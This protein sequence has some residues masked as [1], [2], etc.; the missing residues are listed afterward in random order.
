VTESSH[1]AGESYQLDMTELK[2]ISDFVTEMDTINVL[3]LNPVN[4]K[5]ADCLTQVMKD[6]ED[7]F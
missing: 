1:L 5:Y 3:S 4:F 2:R 6:V 7:P